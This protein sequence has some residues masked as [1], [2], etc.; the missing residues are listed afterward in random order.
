MMLAADNDYLSFRMTNGSSCFHLCVRSA[1][2]TVL[3]THFLLVT[4]DLR[5]AID[6]RQR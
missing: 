3:V 5:K 6:G 2:H 4:E 1:Y